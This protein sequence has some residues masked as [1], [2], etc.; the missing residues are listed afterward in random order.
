MNEFKSYWYITNQ[1]YHYKTLKSAKNDILLNFR[2]FERIRFL[3]GQSIDHIENNRV[4]SYVK[5][6]VDKHGRVTFSR[7]HLL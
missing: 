2:P 6:S 5:I 3:R 7:V 1:P 4:K